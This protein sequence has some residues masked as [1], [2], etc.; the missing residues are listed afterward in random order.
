MV[1][2]KTL[3]VYLKIYYTI[4]YRVSYLIAIHIVQSKFQVKDDENI[5][6][7]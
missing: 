1:T 2:F 6:N 7:P 3:N 5:I 4:E